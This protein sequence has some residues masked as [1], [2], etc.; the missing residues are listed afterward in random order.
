[1]TRLTR[2]SL[3]HR[4]VVMLLS[5]LI[6]ATGV[7]TAGVLK[8]ELIPSMDLPRATVVAVYPGANPEVVERDVARPLESAINAV[9]GITRVT[10][11]SNS[12]FAQ[13]RAEWDYGTSADKVT[14]DIRTAVD[15]LRS[16]LPAEV[17]TTVAAGSFDDLPV[18]ILAVSSD[19]EPQQ[20]ASDVR[21][22]VLPRLKTVAGVREVSLAGEQQRQVTVTLKHEALATYG[23]DSASINQYFTANATGIPAGTVHTGTA[24]LDVQVGRSFA[25]LDDIRQLRLQGTD[26]P[27]ELGQVADVAVAPVDTTTISRV[28]GKA[29][30][31]L[32]VTK[33]P[34]G[35]TVTVAEGVRASLPALE[36]AL[37]GNAEFAVV[38]DQSPFIEQSIHDLTVEGGLGLAMA[39]LV[40]LLFL[41][42]LRPTLITAISI[43]LSLLIALVGLWIGGYTLNILTL[44][45]LTVA[46]GRVVDDSIVVI[47]NIKR[48]ASLGHTG[49]AA[50]VEAVKEVAGAVTSSTLTTVAVFLPIG[51]VG[52][53]AGELFRPFAVTVT[54]ALLASLLVSLTVVPV[55]ASWFMREGRTPTPEKAAKA[56]ARE[57][58]IAEKEAAERVRNE[59]A[60]ERAR[61]RT[62]ARL[63]A[64]GASEA[65]V[66]ASV[67]T[68]RSRYGL[69]AESD[70]HDEEHG[71]S[72]W[73][74]RSYLPAL[75][76]SLAHRA[77]TLLIALGLFAGTMALAPSLK[78][79]FI[80]EAG[81]ASLQIVQD[82]PAGTSLSST[83]A[84][85]RK[86][87]A[88]IDAEPAV[89]TFTTSIG[90][91][92][93][94]L[95][96]QSDVNHASHSV[97]LVAH[98][99]GE[100][101][102]ESLRG[103]IA[104]LGTEAG[105]IQV[106]VGQ[107]SNNVI[108][109]VEGSDPE[110]LKEGNQRVLDAVASVAGLSNVR[111]DLGDARTML[112]VEIDPAKAA[113]AGMTQAQVGLAVTRA[114]RGQKV[115]SLN[116]GD[117]S[118]AVMLR[119]QAPVTDPEALRDVVLPVTQKQT[120]DARTA[121]AEA[122]T[123]RQEAFTAQQKADGTAAYN[124]Q[125]RA[126]R[127]S[128]TKLQAQLKQ[129]QSQLTKLQQAL[130][131][132][133]PPVAPTTPTMPTVDPTAEIRAQIAQLTAGIAQAQ[134]QIASLQ[135]QEDKL[136]ESRTKSLATQS[137]SQAIADAAKAAQKV[138]ADALPLG[139]VATVKTVEAP[140]TITRVDGNRTATI[141][142][143]PEGSDL[144]ATTDA[145]NAALAKVDMPTGTQWRIGGVSQQQR[146]SFAQL[147]LAMAV[148]VGIVYLIMVGTFGSLIQPLMLLVS[149]P[150][151]A[152]GAVGLLLLT[153][154]PLGIPSMIGLLM[155][156]GIVVTNAIVLI[157][158][159]NQLRRRGASV[160]DA[161]M[162]GAR[163]RLRPIVMTALATIMA[164]IPMGLGVTGG[165][166]FISKPL[167]IVVVGGL[168]S[169]TVLT[170]ILVPVLYD[171]VEKARE[172]IVGARRAAASD[173]AATDAAPS[174]AVPLADMLADPASGD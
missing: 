76:W 113:D 59:A 86:V 33:L 7:Y 58:R 161:V 51:L 29:S 174:D 141:T 9:N 49:H 40:I 149:I 108:V 22:V 90:G 152:T 128:R 160:D 132:P 25:S 64:K 135:A 104:E 74:Q 87:E 156:I 39:I 121:A 165:G 45:A 110:R 65:K 117:D 44:G 53:Q 95:G 43:P 57:A 120:I 122:V 151:A 83:D 93:S 17:T 166:V 61:A 99:K 154:T 3:A 62:E 32:Q 88:I 123:A 80:G 77:L 143:T 96:G 2:A 91:G 81:Q 42:S 89:Q 155:L 1:M 105:T 94:L 103:K 75:R 30:L 37:G 163:L 102:A 11:V 144:G 138:T 71:G 145:L 52:G 100:V 18:I 27:V 26:G 127:D 48:H 63:T 55:L 14:G 142:A 68:L 129:Y 134:A 172:R 15:S 24:N 133:Q 34:G 56:E 158:L 66:A 148:A 12:G 20:F 78:T 124:E 70:A 28:N 84:A 41:G 139:A 157:D 112:S 173:A 171:L 114:V 23:V 153:D 131:A 169:S 13:L 69:T 5:L 136:S 72:T 60:F 150:F 92:S 38:F 130:A 16:Q 73:L 8:Q 159:I 167:A 47:E 140:A 168:V 10:S 19:A 119:S 31:T 50:I 85:A 146:D 79:D 36:D 46:I 82:L 125:V 4:T 106:I 116:D 35:N 109:Y 107:S 98:S 162:H 6:I 54:V 170:L 147:G 164:L 118:L 115:G 101:V 21:N 97:S 67:A 137:T 126:L 111:S